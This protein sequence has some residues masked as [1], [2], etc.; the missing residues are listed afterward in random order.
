MRNPWLLHIKWFLII[1]FSHQ[2][3]YKVFLCAFDCFKAFDCY[4]WMSPRMLAYINVQEMH[5]LCQVFLDTQYIHSPVLVCGNW[6]VHNT[7]WRLIHIFPPSPNFLWINMIYWYSACFRFYIFFNK[8]YI[9]IT[10]IILDIIF[11][12]IYIE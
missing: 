12:Y 5:K 7:L 3:N 4:F 9:Y 10:I 8:K 6:W 1:R 2:W 11:L